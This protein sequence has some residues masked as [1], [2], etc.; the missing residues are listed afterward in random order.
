MNNYPFD[1]GIYSWQVT[2]ESSDAQ[3]WFDRGLN[4]IFGYNHEEAITCFENALAIDANFAMAY[5]GIAYCAGP[6]YNMPWELF[7]P[8]LL[9]QSLKTATE[10]VSA[11]KERLAGKSQVEIALI[12]ALEHRHPTTTTPEDL[13]TWSRDYVEQMRIVS[14]TF[15]DDPNV[16]TL[17][18]ESLMNLTPWK[19][20][21]PVTG[22]V[23]E[24]AATMEARE[25]LE[26]S[27]R[28]LEANG[29]SRHPGLLH[30]YIHLMEMSP[31]PEVALRAADELR[32]LVPDAGHL[33][34]M[35]THI[36]VLCGN[37]Q[38]VVVGNSLGIEA[39][40]KYWRQYGAMNLYSMYRIHNY[41]F[42]LYG[43]MFLG[44]YA[45]AM[46]AVAGIKETIP[47]EL[48][49]MESPPMAD[50]IEGYMG[51]KTHVLVRFGKWKELIADPLPE[52][53][54][55]Y[56]ATAATNCY[57]KG[58]AY[59][60]TGNHVA[61][62]QAL[63]DFEKHAAN[64][65]EDRYVHVVSCQDILGVAR[66][67]LIGEM[68]YHQANYELAFSHLRQAVSKEDSLPYDEPWGWMMPSRHALGALLLEQGQIEEA[69][70]VY[71][72]DLGLN[73]SVIRANRHP[74]NVWALLGL[75]ECYD[76]LGRQRDASAIK[77][78]LDFALARSD[79]KINA[80]CF[81]SLTKNVPI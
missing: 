67:M 32:L 76:S 72:A 3:I 35:S 30:L 80:S 23:G 2:T 64:V 43:A 69:M 39:D 20:W 65:S 79:L 47:D 36:D 21:D 33:K 78:R 40:L 22:A 9:E 57:G 15:P 10:S 75:H 52:D 54:E 63:A 68:E 56:C 49:R 25:I 8:P 11:A 4:W 6:N 37:Y 34:H 5:W 27:I 16:A 44:N 45:A 46:D 60:A 26:T 81:C 51:M 24:G 17:F 1:L 61:A 13:Y 41:H 70:S 18:A 48:L 62:K 12:N 50:F 19:M 53:T 7:D 73:D 66:E 77:P 71:E 42:K 58:I 55:L 29:P 74:D 31:T 38:D 28:K 14:H 59:A